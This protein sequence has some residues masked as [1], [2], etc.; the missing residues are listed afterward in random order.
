M[1]E[2]IGGLEVNTEQFKILISI[3][4]SLFSW[5]GFVKTSTAIFDPPALVLSSMGMSENG[6]SKH[7]KSGVT[8]I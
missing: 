4:D 6:E 3:H 8:G 1:L 5:Q 7:Q 2:V